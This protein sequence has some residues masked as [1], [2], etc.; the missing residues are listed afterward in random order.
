MQGQ[1]LHL[2]ILVGPFQL[3][4]F[5]DVFSS[6]EVNGIPGNELWGLWCRDGRVKCKNTEYKCIQTSGLGRAAC[7]RADKST[8]FALL[9]SD[10]FALFADCWHDLQ[11]GS[12]LCHPQGKG[13]GLRAAS[14]RFLHYI[15]ILTINFCIESISKMLYICYLFNALFGTDVGLLFVLQV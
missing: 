2:K 4:T 1:K 6:T 15:K 12:V 11:Y 10:L 5:C 3:D 9:I 13:D 14:P 7:P 8:C